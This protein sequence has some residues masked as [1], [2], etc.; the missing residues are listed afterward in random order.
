MM[1][2]SKTKL[3]LVRQRSKSGFLLKIGH[4]GSSSKLLEAFRYA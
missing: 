4:C 1:R 3:S 2:P